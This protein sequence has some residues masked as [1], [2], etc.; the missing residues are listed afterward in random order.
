MNLAVAVLALGWGCVV[1]A[2]LFALMSRAAARGRASG[3]SGV[4]DAGGAASQ[5]TLRRSIVTA[6][7]RRALAAVPGATHLARVLRGAAGRRRRSKEE[8][9]LVAELPVAIDLLGV[10]VGA[11]CTP[12]IA[13]EVAATWAP[14]RLAARLGEVPGACR[15]GVGVADA[16]GAAGRQTPPLRP[17]TDALGSTVRMGAPVGP[18]L[19]RLAAEARADLRRAAETRARTVPVRLLFPLVFCVLPAFGLLTVVPAVLAGLRSA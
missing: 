2:P 4:G 3:L 14:P 10:A 1:A 17:L 5:L 18:V 13:L 9:A 16:L 7:L 12:F 8:A 11:G 19:A 15:L 6:M